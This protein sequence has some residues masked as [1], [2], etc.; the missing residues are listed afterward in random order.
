M[1][2]SLPAPVSISTANSSGRLDSSGSEWRQT[3]G[4]KLSPAVRFSFNFI[5]DDGGSAADTA[6]L[7]AE[8]L[9]PSALA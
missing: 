9:L 7:S 5:A 4:Q 2:Q 1:T 6:K 8:L 3:I